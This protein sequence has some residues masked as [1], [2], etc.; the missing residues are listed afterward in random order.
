MHFP[1]DSPPPPRHHH[2]CKWDVWGPG[3]AKCHVMCQFRMFQ[4][5][6]PDNEPRKELL[7]PLL[8]L[9]LL[10]HMTMPPENHQHVGRW[11]VDG[12]SGD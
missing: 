11:M 3:N 12:G 4:Y 9:L 6:L 10:L 2:E 7:L 1:H 5:E 8:R